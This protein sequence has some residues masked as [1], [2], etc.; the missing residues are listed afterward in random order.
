M[1]LLTVCWPLK[2]QIQSGFASRYEKAARHCFPNCPALDLAFQRQLQT[3]A[4][5]TTLHIARFR[6]IFEVFR[7]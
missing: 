4:S 2:R 6:R 7:G 3:M 5:A 1:A